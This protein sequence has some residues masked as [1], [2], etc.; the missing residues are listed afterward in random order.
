M[1]MHGEYRM[2][3]KHALL[4]QQLGIPEENTFVMENGEV[5]EIGR[6]RCRISGTVTAGRV[7]IDGLGI[8]DVGN[9]ILKERKLLSE[10]G[11]C[12]KYYL[13]QKERQNS[14]LP[15]NFY[16]GIHI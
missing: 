7:L 5:L 15:R 1:P 8:G 4:A 16:Q 2:L 14:P 12:C 3:Y 10:G 6:R 13:Q 9:T 11:C